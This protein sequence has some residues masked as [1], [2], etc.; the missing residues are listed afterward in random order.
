MLEVTPAPTA[1]EFAAI[2]AALEAL[3][4]MTARERSVPP[5]PSRWHAAAR[6]LHAD[7]AEFP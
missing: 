1:E 6:D 7:E 5:K 3:E 4:A 2:V